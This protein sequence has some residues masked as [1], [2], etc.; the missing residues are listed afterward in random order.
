MTGRSGRRL[1]NSQAIV[2]YYST[3]RLY[4]TSHSTNTASAEG[5]TNTRAESDNGSSY[6]VI[7]LFSWEVWNTLVAAQQ[8]LVEVLPI[9]M[10]GHK[11]ILWFQLETGAGMRMTLMNSHQLRQ[12]HINSQLF[13]EIPR[14]LPRRSWTDV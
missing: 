13:E 5:S 8:V 2:T 3:L 11:L 12:S 6:L 4:T 14:S 10:L 1:S 9:V 7:V